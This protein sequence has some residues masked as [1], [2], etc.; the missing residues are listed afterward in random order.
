M[1]NLTNRKDTGE[2]LRYATF[3]QDLQCLLK[4][5]PSSEKERQSIRKVKHV[6]PQ[7]TH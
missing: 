7:Y 5:E 6:T 2:V 4:L 3:H 1:G